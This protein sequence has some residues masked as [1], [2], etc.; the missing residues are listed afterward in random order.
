MIAAIFDGERRETWFFTTFTALL[1][2]VRAAVFVFKG[3]V[4]FKSAQ[5]IVGLMAKHLSEFRT[6]P[7]FF[8]GQNYM[9]GVQ[10]WIIA[11]LFWI[12]RPAVSVMKT[13]LVL[14]NISAALLLMRGVS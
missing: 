11:P 2:V 5:A 4:D 9:L 3:Y 13:P 10:S 12:A 6:F 7:M 14:L 8:Y 1:V